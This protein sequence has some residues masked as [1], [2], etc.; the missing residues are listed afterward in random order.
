ERVNELTNRNKNLERRINALN[1]RLNRVQDY[2]KEVKKM[3]DEAINKAEWYDKAGAWIWQKFNTGLLSGGVGV[4]GSSL[5]VGSLALAGVTFP[6]FWPIVGGA[7]L[8]AAITG[9][10]L[11][12]TRVGNFLDRWRNNMKIPSVLRKSLK[13]QQDL[14]EKGIVT[15][16]AGDELKDFRIPKRGP[17][18]APNTIKIAPG[19]FIDKKPITE[20]IEAKPGQ[21]VSGTVAGGVTLKI[22]RKEEALLAQKTKETEEKT[23]VEKELREHQSSITKDKKDFD[24]AIKDLRAQIKDNKSAVDQSSMRLMSLQVKLAKAE[25]PE[26]TAITNEFEQEQRILSAARITL[27]R[28]EDALKAMEKV[29]SLFKLNDQFQ[30]T[31]VTKEVLESLYKGFHPELLDTIKKFAKEQDERTKKAQEVLGKVNQKQ[32]DKWYKEL[33]A[34]D[35]TGVH[36]YLEEIQNA[37]TA[38]EKLWGKMSDFE[39]GRE[40]PLLREMKR[41]HKDLYEMLISLPRLTLES[42]YPKGPAGYDDMAGK[43]LE[44]WEGAAAKEE[45]RE[46]E[47]GDEEN[48]EEGERNEAL[49]TKRQEV[50]T[51]Y[52]ALTTAAKTLPHL[53]GIEDVLDKNFEA[54]KEF[55]SQNRGGE[56]PTVYPTLIRNKGGFKKYIEKHKDVKELGKW[57]SLLEAIKEKCVVTRLD[58]KGKVRGDGKFGLETKE[59]MYSDVN[60]QL[61]ELDKELA[62]TNTTD[63]NNPLDFSQIEIISIDSSE[64]GKG[65]LKCLKDN[66][67]NTPCLFDDLL[68]VKANGNP[69]A[70]MKGEN[71]NPPLLTDNANAKYLEAFRYNFRKLIELLKKPDNGNAL[72]KVDEVDNKW[73]IVAPNPPNKSDTGNKERF[74]YV[75]ENGDYKE[76]LLQGASGDLIS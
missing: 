6:V 23:F 24:A 26:K 50:I 27:G 5:T 54:I 13:F 48:E 56:N 72:M 62:N 30:K 10:I 71:E 3:R 18:E 20:V 45:G 31:P 19:G 40:F 53:K 2:A 14:L 57:K 69:Q 35:R 11:R 32:V 66:D 29:E 33:S 65:P 34:D 36:D 38:D 49:N 42:R 46:E 76:I 58:E 60:T 68:I 67:P 15:I 21:L 39:L 51:A 9:G 47:G 7:A 8:G 12:W 28:S 4:L 22:E 63:F 43:M 52:E 61:S 55:I 25:E 37:G 17:G 44:M 59:K 73:S 75:E 1:G 16:S 74:V 70:I 64:G 41:Y